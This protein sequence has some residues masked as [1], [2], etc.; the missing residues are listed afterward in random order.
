M[1]Y[2]IS[3]KIRGLV[4]KSIPVINMVWLVAGCGLCERDYC[5]YNDGTEMVDKGK[6]MLI[7]CGDSVINGIG[8][9]DKREWAL[10]NVICE[11]HNNLNVEKWNC[12]P[13][14]FY[15]QTSN[16]C[17]LPE[18]ACQY[19][20]GMTMERPYEEMGCN[21][22]RIIDALSETVD[23]ADLVKT[24]KCS[25]TCLDNGEIK[26]EYHGDNKNGNIVM[27]QSIIKNKMHTI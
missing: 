26:Y 15:N 1:K 14:S 21:D 7:S 3:G 12:T 18:G 10:C 4:Q 13:P 20:N 5:I 16:S 25:A 2:K 8:I 24:H 6:R 9:I 19:Q 17:V 27:I 11:G 23:S 22:S